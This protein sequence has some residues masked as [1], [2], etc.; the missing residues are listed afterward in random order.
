VDNPAP[1]VPCGPVSV[2]YM[3][4]VITGG[5][6]QIARHL[7]RKLVAAGHEPVGIVRNAAHVADLETDGGEGF[8][9]DLEQTDVE[10]L[11]EALD[12]ADAVVFAAGGGADGNAARKESVDKGAA[13]ML[14]DAATKAGVSR[15][16]MVSSMGTG[17]ADPD[18]DDV[19]QV[20]LRAKLAADEYLQKTDL[21]WT[22][23]RPGRLEDGPGTG[24]V[25]VGEL[26]SG[27]VTREDVA[28]VLVASLDL[29]RTVGKTFDL[30]NGN[31]EIAEAL[32]T[33]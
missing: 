24:L 11:A 31:D 15:Y 8:E 6:G 28:S 17:D 19:F 29:T 23:I 22:I 18:S 7:G 4:I 26:P 3:R 2:E 27:S 25:Q 13:I 33:L 32:R 5:H 12:G 20:Y 1:S 30:L 21:A 9:L 14:A 10:E 16:L